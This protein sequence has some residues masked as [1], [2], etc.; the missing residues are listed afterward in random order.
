MTGLGARIRERR[1]EL[2]LTKRQLAERSGISSAY[3][4]Q[5]ENGMRVNPSGK[6]LANLCKSLDVSIERLLSGNEF[7]PEGKVDIPGDLAVMAD[8]L[9]L[10]FHHVVGLV[11]VAK[12]LEQTSGQ[13]RL[14]PVHWDW[15]RL[16]VGIKEWL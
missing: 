3:V 8:H 13:Y 7:T 16:Y 1:K 2:K 6:I 14:T 4:R 12:A 9:Q 11:R 15:R 5:L 10:P